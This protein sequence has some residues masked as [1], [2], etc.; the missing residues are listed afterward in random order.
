VPEGRRLFPGMTV[1]DNLLLGG[2]SIDKKARLEILE[3]IFELFPVIKVRSKQYAGTLS[4]GE[5]Q[6]VA[7]ARALMGK[8]RLLMLDEPS[9]G[10][11]P[12]MVEET[13][14]AVKRI[15]SKGTTVLLVEQNVHECLDLT[16]RAYVL[17]NGVIV[18]SGSS[19]ELLQSERVQ[20]AYLGI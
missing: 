10:L 7:I 11:A 12:K 1:Y 4:G 2:Y 8:P 18:Q 13:F 5:Q 16:S 14:E 6:M 19:P 17:E 3:D 20:Q 15:N 9:L